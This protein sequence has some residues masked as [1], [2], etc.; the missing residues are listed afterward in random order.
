LSNLAAYALAAG[1]IQDAR[2]HLRE[3]LTLQRSAGAG[4]LA[5]VV[6]NH[7]LFAA[8]LGEHE[9]AAL[10]AGFGDAQYASRGEVRQHTENW[11]YERL[12]T[13]LAN[14]Y[15]ADELARQFGAGA[16]LTEEQALELAAAIHELAMP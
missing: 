6:E 8:T 4:W 13:L 11:G 7:A 1:D 16:R 15:A 2:T 5:A 3:A 12:R 9:R 14:A 10:L